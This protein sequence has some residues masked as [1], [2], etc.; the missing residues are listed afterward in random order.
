[1]D[2]VPVSP[3]HRE[4]PK[5]WKGLVACQPVY[6]SSEN[7]WTHFYSLKKFSSFHAT[8]WGKDFPFGTLQSY[9]FLYFPALDLIN[10]QTVAEEE[11][12]SPEL[13]Q[14][15]QGNFCAMKTKLP[16]NLLFHVPYFSLEVLRTS[17]SF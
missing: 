6:Q 9:L 16:E 1:M 4:Q 11:T 12:E 10:F 17:I 14:S 15:L 2:I 3:F 8:S 5:L 7:Q 13:L